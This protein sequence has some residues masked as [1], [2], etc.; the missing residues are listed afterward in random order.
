LSSTGGVPDRKRVA[1][2]VVERSSRSKHAESVVAALAPQGVVAFATTF[3]DN[4]GIARVKA[5]PLARLPHLAAWGVGFSTAFDY[6]RFDDWV[7]APPTGEGP[8]GDQRIIPDLSRVVTLSAQPG[9]AWSPGERWSQAGEPH[10][11]CSRLL[12]RRQVDALAERGIDVQAAF[13]IEW[14]VSRGPGDGFTAATG[15]SGY[16][17]SRLVELSDYCRD[18]VGALTDEGVVVE[19]FHPEYAAGQFEV[20]VAPE[21]PLAA[22]DTS[23]LVRTT[24][25]ALG[26]AHGLRTSFSPKVDTAGVGNG[27]HVHLSL[28]RDGRNLMADG[29]RRF[30]LTETG[31]AFSASVLRRLP[32]LL[33][34]GAPGVASY[35]RLVP[36]HWAGAYA[37]WG[38]ENREAAMRMVT[39]STGSTSWAAN[40]EVKCF[41]LLANPYLVL[42]GLLA[43]GAAG[44]DAGTEL[45][46]PVDVDPAALSEEVLEQRGIRRLPS[47][48]REAVDLFAADEVIAAAFGQP[49]V[50]AIVAVRESELELFADAIPEE[51]AAATRWLH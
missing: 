37:C 33:A 6:F 15:G 26:E 1:V 27:G 19:Q 40:M 7:A 48:L 35:L 16:G 18:V 51:V 36:Q 44:I 21:S 9:W 20:S 3:V 24:V 34:V 31:A 13:E 43:T 32:A 28:W 39:G 17:M 5:V 14:A 2:D 11:K 50:D 46:D 45:P 38:L 47:S 25:R 42:A 30:E 49:L 4:S 8:V 23:V 41:D 22:A 29:D 12:L 10:D